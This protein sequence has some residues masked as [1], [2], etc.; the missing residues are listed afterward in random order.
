MNKI[1]NSFGYFSHVKVIL[2]YLC[3]LKIVE[4]SLILTNIK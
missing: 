2:D 3:N 1:A 4:N